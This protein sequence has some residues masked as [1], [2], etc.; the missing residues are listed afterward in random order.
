M[1]IVGAMVM[2]AWLRRACRVR[3][4]RNLLWFCTIGGC[5]CL[6]ESNFAGVGC[7]GALGGS[8]LGNMFDLG[9]GVHVGLGREGVSCF[10]ER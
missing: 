1:R 2:C 9:L 4:M 5:A 7:G 3:S 10:R 8:R 6:P